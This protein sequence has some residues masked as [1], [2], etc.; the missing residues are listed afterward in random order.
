MTDFD[1]DLFVIGAGS[2][3]VRAARIAATHGARVTIAEEFRIGGTCVIRGCV[4]KKIMVYASRFADDFED[5][6]GFGWTV[7][8]TSFEWSKLV[9]AKEAEVTRLSGIYRQNL[10]RAGVTMIEARATVTGP[11]TVAADSRTISARHI[12]VATGASPVMD[13]PVP[14]I[15]H[16][17]SS[18]EIFDLPDFPR[19]I[20]IVGGGY[21]AVEFASLLAR[22]GAQVTLVVR[23]P[24]L[25]RGFDADMADALAEALRHAGVTVSTRTTIARIEK[26]DGLLH[27]T[28][29]NGHTAACDQVMLAIGRKPHTH[30]LGLESAGVA[31]GK[32]GA[33]KV[34]AYSRTNLASIHAVGDVTDRINLTPV[35]IR[36]GHAF[37]DTV[38]GNK[39]TTV[40]HKNVASAVFTTPEIGA[41]G[42]TEDEARAR[43]D[44]VDIYATKFKPLKATISGR[45]ER[46]AMKIIVDGTTDR[47]LGVHIFGHDAGEMAQLVG[48]AIHMG[49]SKADFDATMAVHPTAA[50]ELVTLRTRSAR[51]ER[52]PS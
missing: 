35:A 16:A 27:A 49:A 38:F 51:H 4:P 10:T 20:V 43:F 22:L 2:G 48:I 39:P 42:L 52:P 50:E 21:I 13:D 37:A 19:R 41:C 3:G 11:H 33:I 34:D 17:I 40:D 32:G 9:R 29:S 46:V 18:N 44:I 12:L 47:V 23:G 31:L 6:K 14:G 24:S 8:D 7:G 45:D 1:C 26:R 28:L 15:E 25:L 36:E 5:A 30:G